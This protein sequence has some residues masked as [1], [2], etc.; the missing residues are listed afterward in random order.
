MINQV[1]TTVQLTA[2]MG[3][4][5][6]KFGTLNVPVHEL[7]ARAN[8]DAINGDTTLAKYFNLAIDI[9]INNS[10]ID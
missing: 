5:M 3:Y 6:Q 1:F 7:I 4:C 2:L 9:A 10:E 8:I